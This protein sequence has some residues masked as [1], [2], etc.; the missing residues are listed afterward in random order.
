MGMTTEEL[1]PLKDPRH[2]N[3][4]RHSQHDILV[5]ALCT[6]LFSSETCTDYSVVSP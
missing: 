1:K 5:I 2:R 3:A 4:E 6:T